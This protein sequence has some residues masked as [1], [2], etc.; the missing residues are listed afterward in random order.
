ME[1]NLVGRAGELANLKPPEAADQPTKDSY[2]LAS[3]AGLAVLVREPIKQLRA[4]Y[5]GLASAAAV[6]PFI[7]QIRAEIFDVLGRLVAETAPNE[8]AKE[9]ITQRL[10]PAER[11]AEKDRA[12]VNGFTAAL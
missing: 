5:I 4:A 1:H 6:D 10:A 2:E 8:G 9:E 3:K 12:V 7:F 11:F